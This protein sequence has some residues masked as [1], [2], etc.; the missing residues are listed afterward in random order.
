MILAI[1]FMALLTVAHGSGHCTCARPPPLHKAFCRSVTRAKVTNRD[2]NEHGVVTYK[3]EHQEIYR[4]SAGGLPDE[5]STP[6]PDLCGLLEDLVTGQEYLIGGKYVARS[7][8]TNS[9]TVQPCKEMERGLHRAEQLEEFQ[10]E[11][12]ERSRTTFLGNE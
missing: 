12:R 8:N 6:S 1:V 5:V 3:L 10:F 4:P 9:I 7:G 11:M 2:V